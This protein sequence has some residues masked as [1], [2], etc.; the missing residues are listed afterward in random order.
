[1][2]LV[3][4]DRVILPKGDRCVYIIHVGVMHGDGDHYETKKHTCFRKEDA[5]NALKVLS[6]YFKAKKNGYVEQ[7]HLNNHFGL[8]GEADVIA[9]L[10][11][12]M[13]GNDI[14][15][16]DGHYASIE[17]IRV[18]YY[19]GLGDEY[20]CDIHTDEMIVVRKINN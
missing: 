20:N 14:T 16:S 3:I 6:C 19:D 7:H 5:I 10:Y 8:L 13:V 12:D 1:M 17:E 18:T 4:S 2:N 11:Y 15:S 9:D